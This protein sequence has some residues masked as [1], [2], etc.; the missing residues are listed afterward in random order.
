LKIWGDDSSMELKIKTDDVEIELQEYNKDKLKG[1]ID[2]L[3]QHGT[4]NKSLCDKLDKWLIKREKIY[5]ETI[6]EA[7]IQLSQW[8]HT[9]GKG[10]KGRKSTAIEI[11]EHLFKTVLPRLKDPK[12]R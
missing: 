7:I 6:T 5:F 9:V 2:Q 4:A 10:Y 11:S 1:L 8:C 12:K 3:G